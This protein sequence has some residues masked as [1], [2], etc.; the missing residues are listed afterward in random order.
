MKR[1]LKGRLDLAKALATDDI[2]G[3]SYADVVLIV[4]AVLSACA[5]IRWP[6]RRMDRRRFVEL[7]VSHSPEDFRTAWVSIPALVNEGLVLE[8]D[9]PYAGGNSTRIF[10]DEEID[11]SLQDA[12][13]RYPSVPEGQLRKHCYATLIYEWLRCGYAH[14]YCPYEDITHVPPSRANAR[15]S[16]IVRSTGKSPRRMISFHLPYLF[17][18]AEHHVSILPDTATSSPSAWWIDQK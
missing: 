14:E 6:G 9:T 17:D 10:R 13:T 2:P 15:V 11:L 5:S 8:N 12:R 1:F 4:T 3:A 18:I 16:Y 7:L